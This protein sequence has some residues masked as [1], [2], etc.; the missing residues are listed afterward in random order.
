MHMAMHDSVVLYTEVWEQFWLLRNL[1]LVLMFVCVFGRRQKWRDL[2]TVQQEE[3]E[4]GSL[5][6]FG[7]QH[8][9]SFLASQL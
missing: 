5:S 2:E 1:T 4:G 6:S 3:R 8:L 9:H 7:I